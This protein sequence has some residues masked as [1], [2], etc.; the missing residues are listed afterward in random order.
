MI[1]LTHL[2]RK[3]IIW[4]FTLECRKFFEML[5]KAFTTALVLTHWVPN[6]Q[7]TFKTDTSNYALTAILSIVS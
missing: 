2:T 7:I 1:L 3:G 6:A 5:K 4:N